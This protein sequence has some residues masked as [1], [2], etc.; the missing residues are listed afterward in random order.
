MAAAMA[1][2]FVQQGEIGGTELR[3]RVHRVRLLRA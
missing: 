3:D 1:A 2:Q